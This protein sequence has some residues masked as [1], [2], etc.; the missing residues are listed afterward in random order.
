M[1]QLLCRQPGALE[2]RHVSIGAAAVA[3]RKD[4]WIHRG[5][6]AQSVIPAVL[7]YPEGS[8]ALQPPPKAAVPSHRR[9]IQAPQL[10][11]AGHLPPMPH[12]YRPWVPA[13]K[14]KFH[15]QAPQLAPQAT[16]A[17]A[18]LRARFSILFAH[19]GAA[20]CSTME[21]RCAIIERIMLR[22][23]LLPHGDEP[24]FW[25]AVPTT[26]LI[27]TLYA[28]NVTL[29]PAQVLRDVSCCATHKLG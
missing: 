21:S 3:Q 11:L 19:I 6:L 5:S 29:K 8:P 27:D 24:A 18:S 4:T 15:R 16:W 23:Q 1:K 9:P 12:C 20:S 14:R 25:R 7:Q 10:L 2:Q 17:S 26:W 28:W 13:T 22:Q